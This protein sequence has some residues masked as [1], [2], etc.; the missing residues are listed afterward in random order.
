MLIVFILISEIK[1]VTWMQPDMYPEVGL[2]ILLLAPEA[3][4]LR[5]TV[6]YPVA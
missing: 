1:I 3:T 4:C 5:E 2:G 6:M